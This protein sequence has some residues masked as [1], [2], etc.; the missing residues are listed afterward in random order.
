MAGGLLD[1]ARYVART[2]GT[3]IREPRSGIARIR[4]RLDLRSDRR[5]WESL[6]KQPAE[7]YAATD[8]A[9]ERLHGAIGAPWPCPDDR[10]FDDRWQ[11]MLDFFRSASA[12]HRA[13]QDYESQSAALERDFDADPTLARAAWCLV[14][15]LRPR[16][17]VETGVARGVTSRFLLEG[18]AANGDG[19]LWSI[20]LPHPQTTRFE[21]LGSAV[22]PALRDRWE[23]RLGTSAE[24]LPPLLGELGQIDMFVHDS[25]HT[26]RNVR[27]EL[28]AAWPVLRPGGAILLD[29]LHTNLGF[30]E[31]LDSAQPAVWLTGIGHRRKGIWGMAIKDG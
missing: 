28:E 14:R 26:T 6:G 10:E 18:L 17:I 4:G 15:H 21:Q 5:A 16:T 29:D 7:L 22:S 3:L 12:E 20:D 8:H 11:A 27:F 9:T 25:L 24:Q 19:R 1:Q 23:L 30:R 2:A 13:A 31:F